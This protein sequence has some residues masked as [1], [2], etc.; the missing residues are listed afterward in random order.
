MKISKTVLLFCCLI[1]GGMTLLNACIVARVG[2]PTLS[3]AYVEIP[4]T[5]LALRELAPAILADPGI[6]G[7]SL[8]D[9]PAF[10][11]KEVDSGLVD[12]RTPEDYAI[13]TESLYQEGFLGYL[14][15]RVEYPDT[16]RSIPEMNYETFLA[17]CNVFPDVDFSQYSVL[18]YEATGTGCTVTFEKHVYRDDQNKQILYELTVVEEGACETAVRNRNLIFVPR[19]PHDYSVTFSMSD[20]KE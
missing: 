8:A 18:G 7:C 9:L 12:I 15:D 1:I 11:W 13:R 2:E 20:R 14:Q 4:Y 6:S 19:I 17:T 5:E 16:Y 3:P 10:G